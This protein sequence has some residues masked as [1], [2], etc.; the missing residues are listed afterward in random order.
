MPS[1]NCAVFAPKQPFLAPTC[2]ETRSTRPNEGHQLLHSTCALIAPSPHAHFSKRDARPYAMLKQV[3]LA[4][5]KPESMRF[6]PCKIPK[7]L[8]KGPS[9]DQKGVK[10]GSKMRHSLS[11]LGPFGM[12]KQV[13]LAHFEPMV[14]RFGASKIPKCLQNG[15]SRDQKWVKNAFFQKSW[16]IWD[17]QTSA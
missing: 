13:I 10:N 6:G 2:P 11:Y 12:L 8:E 15:P 3:F 1:K 17:A 4:H 5:F 7:C 9:W 14:T 16:T